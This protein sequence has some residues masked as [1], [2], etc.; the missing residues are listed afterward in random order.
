MRRGVTKKLIL[1]TQPHKLD[2]TSKA[3]KQGNVAPSFSLSLVA[4]NIS[5]VY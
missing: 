5:F 3:I 1:H 2:S 4:V